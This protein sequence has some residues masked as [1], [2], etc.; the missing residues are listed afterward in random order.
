MVMDLLG[1]SLEDLF[2]SCKRKFSLKTVCMLAD[3]MVARVEYVHS[4]NFIHRD[5]K[6]DNFLMG[7]VKDEGKCFLVDYGLA[8][9]YKDSRTGE[10]IPYRDHKSM[11]G[12][13]RYASMNTHLGIEQARRDD[14]EGIGFILVYFLKG[15][16]P[17]QGLNAKTKKEKYDKIKDKKVQTTIE[18]LTRGLPEELKKY[19]QHARNL[20]FDEKPD[21]NYCRGLF[22][23]CLERHGHEYDCQYDWTKK[24]T[25]PAATERPP[26][27]RPVEE[28][29]EFRAPP[30]AVHNPS[31]NLL[32][33]IRERKQ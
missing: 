27:V 23:D 17:W 11:T 15:S 9:K 13:A 1:Q 5:M 32:D 2:V 29:K 7:P 8:K 10:H 19:L 16:L 31:N 21:Y 12:T 18:A 33:E 30:P 28:Q 26:Q 24:G 25:R 22:R 20:K 3:Q 14:L 6:P 4:K